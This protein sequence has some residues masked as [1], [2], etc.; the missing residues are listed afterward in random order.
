MMRQPATSSRRKKG[1]S[2]RLATLLL[3][4]GSGLGAGQTRRRVPEHAQHDSRPAAKLPPACN[5]PKA[6]GE[7]DRQLRRAMVLNPSP[8]G[9][10]ARGASFAQHD[11]LIC[12]IPSFQAALDLDPTFWE[13]R[14]NLALVL[15]KKRAP[16]RAAKEL[17]QV[18]KEKPDFPAGHNALGRANQATREFKNVNN[19]PRL[20]E[21]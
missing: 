19:K 15:M 3:C 6:L 17:R 11:N 1:W 16:E 21:C 7:G 2:V 18:V 13:A 10:T 20:V 5:N 14:F 12:A 9:D 4:L 8:Q